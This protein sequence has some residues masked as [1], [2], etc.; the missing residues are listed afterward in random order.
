MNNL[1]DSVTRYLEKHLIKNYKLEWQP[2]EGIKNVV[3][4]PAIAEYENIPLLINSFLK[5]DRYYFNS[6]LIIFVIN[7]T[8]SSKSEVKTN[9][10]ITLKLLRS[11][12][13][14]QR[15]EHPYI[16]DA[17]RSGLKI[18]LVDAASRGKEFDDKTGGVGLARK[19]GMDLA[20]TVFDYTEPGKNILFC[21][22]ADCTVSSNYLKEIIDRFNKENLSAAYINFE[23]NLTG[24]EKNAAAI[25]SYEIFLRY[26][27]V[28]LK[29]AGSPYAFHTIG[30]TIICDADAYITNG[31]MN[32][33]KAAEDFYF[34]E[35]LSKNFDVV[36]ISSA[37]VYPSNRSSWRVPFGTGQRVTR[38]LSGK[39]NEYLLHN[40]K[41]FDA[42]KMWLQVFS[43][44][45][46]DNIDETL[47]KAK[48][49]HNGLY[50][51]LVEQD[52]KNDWLNIIKHSNSVE[53]LERQKKLWFDGF[54]TLKLIHH[55]RDS[56][57]ADINMFD[58]LDILF[59]RMGMSYNVKRKDGTIPELGVQRE[60]LL[61]LREIESEL[62]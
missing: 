12:I 36:R 10:R 44:M 19:I 41:S 37:E 29:L 31:G 27:V 1:P 59:G 30:S 35:K 40:P 4:I 6:T 15:V 58:A 53:Q 2:C 17:I 52:F 22:D 33:R 3:V 8:V 13:N 7:H 62:F 61:K 48:T 39:R 43:E 11:L 32:K 18:G 60:Y 14:K 47:E 24:R 34:L 9:N 54:R 55:F 5:N 28:E 25:I 56:A 57:F 26:Y 20:L 38:F 46:S 49:I 42:L 23:H 16:N 21:T 50:N 45:D 51:F